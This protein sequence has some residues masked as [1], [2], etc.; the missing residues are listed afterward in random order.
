MDVQ[1]EQF[2]IYLNEVKHSSENTLSSYRRDLRKF[3]DYLRG[4]GIDE[5]GE[6]S[7]VTMQ[8]YMLELEKSGLASATVSRNIAAVKS[9]YSYLFRFSRVPFNPA[10]DLK[11]P[12]VTRKAPELMSIEEVSL[13]LAQPGSDSSKVIRDKAMLE[14]LYATGI[15][16][17]ELVSLTLDDVNIVSGYIKCTRRGRTRIIPFGRMAR[18]ALVDYM[19][20]ARAG[21]IDDPE[22][23]VLFVNCSGSPMSRQG[24]WKILKS[25]ARAAGIKADITP[26]SLRHS[27]AAHL[28]ENGA[29]LRSVQEMMGDSETTAVQ[30]YLK[31]NNARIRDVYLQTHPRA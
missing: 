31:K 14:L 12:K 3:L 11:A 28:L 21:M 9:F 2:I 22:Q 15:R 8:A 24:F 27:F 13:L 17:S 26:H 16:V 6:V 29:D 4:I 18:T 10:E 23:K 30:N 7:A 5:L 1:L 25:Y 19:E 20:N